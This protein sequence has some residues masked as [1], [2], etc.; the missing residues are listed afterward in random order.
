MATPRKDWKKEWETTAAKA[1]KLA[2]R[3][4]QRMKRL[5]EYA[6]RPGYSGIKKYAYARAEDYIKNFID[7]EER[8]S[9]K[10]KQLPRFIEN[11]RL[12]PKIKG[13]DSEEVFKKNVQKIRMNIKAMEEFLGS[14]S[15]TL[16]ESRSGKKTKGIKAIYD[17]RAQTITDEFLK[18]YGYSMS[19]DDL[20]RFFDSKKQAKLEAEVGS[21]QMFIVASVIRKENIRGS[22]KELEEYVKTHVKV[23]DPSELNMKKNESR[24]KYLE[25]MRDKLNYTKD[26]VL[27]DM[28]TNALK[29]GINAS[30]I[31]IN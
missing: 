20:K 28:I 14:E 21:K 13:D 31:F 18:K 6:K 4:N 26:N 9:R 16:G 7:T 27:N 22:R 8:L 29:A 17:K 1:R 10:K 24:A 30:N 11:V 19:A 2:K 25:R 12:D 23:D 3:A 15:S 5:E